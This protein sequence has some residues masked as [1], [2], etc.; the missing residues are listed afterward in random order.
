MVGNVTSNHIA[1]HQISNL[2]R[3]ISAA[4]IEK[5]QRDNPSLQADQNRSNKHAGK[6]SDLGD[7][8][9]QQERNRTREIRDMQEGYQNIIKQYG[10]QTVLFRMMETMGGTGTHDS[11]S[12][13]YLDTY[14]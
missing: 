1:Y 12:G 8:D 6:V 9:R 4:R 5:T 7:S 11:Q 10:Q 3:D 13:I 14:V 2:S